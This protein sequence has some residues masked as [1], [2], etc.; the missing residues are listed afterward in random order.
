MRLMVAVLICLTGGLLTHA[1]FDSALG[2]WLA[3]DSTVALVAIRFLGRVGVW[4]ADWPDLFGR[5][6]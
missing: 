5:G 4:P 1:L 3:M 2:A 6:D